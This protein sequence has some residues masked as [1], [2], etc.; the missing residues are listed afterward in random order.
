[1]LNINKLEVNV[2]TFSCQN[3]N[4]PSSN[5]D[6]T[7]I[8]ILLPSFPTRTKDLTRSRRFACPI[9]GNIYM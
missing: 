4:F 8:T 2:E 1:M 9:S 6:K 7:K 5:N 3:C